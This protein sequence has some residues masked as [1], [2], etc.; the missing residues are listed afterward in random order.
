[1]AGRDF[2]PRGCFGDFVDSFDP[3]RIVSPP[4]A[5]PGALFTSLA[6]R[7]IEARDEARKRAAEA[8]EGERILAALMR[9][10]PEGVT[11]AEG[12]Q[13]TIK[14][15]ST[16]G[17][18]MIARHRQQ[19][20]DIPAREQGERWQLLDRWEMRSNRISYRSRELRSAASWSPT[21]S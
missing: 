2:H 19:T 1:L 10:V 17:Q 20:Q 8:E 13:L 18:R 14:M 3:Q 9:Y 4:Q 16:Y 6:I 15:T 11:I 12:P 7:H 5:S 21:K